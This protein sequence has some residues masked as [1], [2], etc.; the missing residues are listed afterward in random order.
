MLI[1]LFEVNCDVSD[2]GIGRC[3]IQQ[4]S[5]GNNKPIAFAYQKLTT[6]QNNCASFEKEAWVV[7]FGLNKFDKWIYEARIEINSDHYHFK[8]L[9]QATS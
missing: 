5:E 6:T 7:V 3:L 9:N 1:Y 8:Y 2:Y 4:D